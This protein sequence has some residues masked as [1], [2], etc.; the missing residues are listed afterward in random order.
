[1]RMA[2]S[3]S[4]RRRNRLPSAK[5]NSTVCGSTFTTSI[6]ASIALSGCSLRRKLSPLKYDNG[7][8]RDSDINCLMSTRA[9]SQPKAKNSGNPRSHQNSNSMFQT[10]SQISTSNNGV[11]SRR[12]FGRARPRTHFLAQLQ[13]FAALAVYI[14]QASDDARCNTDTKKDQQHQRQRCLPMGAKIKAH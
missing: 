2:R 11:S 8:A 7:N 10:G 3:T 12:V 5:C 6:K 1:M 13:D 9:A 4:P 14:S